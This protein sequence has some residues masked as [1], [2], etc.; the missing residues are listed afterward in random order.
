VAIRS[1]YHIFQGVEVCGVGDSRSR[2]L[3]VLESWSILGVHH[4]RRAMAPGYVMDL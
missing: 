2:G 3:G 1:L 4:F